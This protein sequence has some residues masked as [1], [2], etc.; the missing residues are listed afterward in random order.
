MGP[1]KRR[2]GLVKNHQVS[3]TTENK[4]GGGGRFPH[5]PAKKDHGG[6]EKKGKGTSRKKRGGKCPTWGGTSSLGG[7]RK[8]GGRGG[9]SSA[10]AEG[11]GG[12][13]RR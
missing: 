4:K 11:G 13:K 10:S 9:Y 6:R 8:I 2:E 3:Y 1:G 12:V 5:L 7:E